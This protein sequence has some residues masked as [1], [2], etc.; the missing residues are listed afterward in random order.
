ESCQDEIHGLLPLGVAVP[1]DLKL[2]LRGQLCV[3]E[4]DLELSR[5]VAVVVAHVIHGRQARASAAE[6]GCTAGCTLVSLRSLAVARTCPEQG[7]VVGTATSHERA[8]RQRDSEKAE[9]RSTAGGRIEP[10]CGVDAGWAHRESAL[11]CV[12]ACPFATRRRC[13]LLADA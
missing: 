3:C 6:C 12:L 4:D 1:T 13:R 9:E 5:P 10:G 7:V 8:E 2:G 11:A